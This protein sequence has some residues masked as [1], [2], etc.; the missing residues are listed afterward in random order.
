MAE[1]QSPRKRPARSGRQ[2]LS[3]PDPMPG[4]CRTTKRDAE[5]E[6]GKPASAAGAIGCMRVWRSIVGTVITVITAITAITAMIVM[7]V[8]VVA[9]VGNCLASLA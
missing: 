6:S 4:I 7:V 8:M 1:R 2:V 3:M 9:I 5:T